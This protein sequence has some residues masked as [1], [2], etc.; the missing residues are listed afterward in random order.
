MRN[1]DSKTLDTF[2]LFKGLSV[3]ELKLIIKLVKTTEVNP[4]TVI[5]RENDTGD[6]LYLLEE[7]VVD[8]HKTLTVVTSKQEFGT[9]ERSFIRLT[10]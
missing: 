4:G 5:I 9:K 8:I 7:G 10:G 6:E 1:V 3:D 2:S